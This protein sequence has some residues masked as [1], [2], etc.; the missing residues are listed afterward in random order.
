[1]KNIIIIGIPRS[2]KST[3]AKLIKDKYPKYNQ[4]S[5]EAVRNA[6]IKTQPELE[7]DNRNS[8]SRKELL[9]Q[10]I[11]SLVEWNSKLLDS[12]I[13]IEGSFTTIDVLDNIIDKDNNI[14]ICLGLGCR[15]IEDI[16]SGIRNNDSSKDYTSNWS[17][18]K[19]RNHFYDSE[20]VD[21][22]N[23]NYCINHNI[24]Y[25]DT[26]NNRNEIFESI[27]NNIQV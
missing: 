15:N 11:M 24:K 4:I 17:D 18:E 2:G 5:F 8:I 1:M 19:I 22:V 14:I 7:M 10:F 26:Y 16:L 9:P 6:F 12:P 25:Y 21:K 27:I 20:E 23:Y 13:L 3:L